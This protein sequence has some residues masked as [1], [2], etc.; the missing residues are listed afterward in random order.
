MNFAPTATDRVLHDTWVFVHGDEVHLFYLAMQVGNNQH[1]LIGHAVSADWLHWT[2]LPYIDLAGP[3]GSWDAGRVGTG[4]TF[5]GADGRFYMAYTGRIDPQEDIGLAVSDDLVNWTKVQDTPVWPQALTP[6][7]ETDFR[8][9]GVFQAW[10]DPFVVDLPDGNRYALLCAKRGDG[11]LAARACVAVARLDDLHSWTTREPLRTPPLFPTMEVPEIFELEGRWWLTFNAH[12]GWGRRLDTASRTMAGGT[13]CL[14]AEEPFG[15]WQLPEDSLLIGSGQ[16]RHDAVVA[17]SVLWQGER[18]VYHHYN[19]SGETGSARALGLP[20]VV[21][22]VGNRLVLRPWPGLAAIQRPAD[23]PTDWQAPA[24][25]PFSSGIWEVQNGQITGRCEHGAAVCVAPMDSSDV[26]LSCE[27]HLH[28]A[29]RAG[30]GVAGKADG[31]GAAVVLLDAKRHQVALTELR[32]GTFGPVLDPPVD[33]AHCLACHGGAH[34]LRVLK[35]HR[36][37]EAFLDDELVFST[38]WKDTGAGNHLVAVVEGGGA[39]VHPTALHAL[40]PMRRD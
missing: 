37:I 16:G 10:R 23:V 9:R 20:K 12:G 15:E 17:R 32:A 2:E 29:E 19:G 24:A 36:Y 18:L 11:P 28:E 21:E 39:M 35:R 27:I 31:L 30:I 1:R 5:Q 22:A 26:D 8:E 7:Y 6:P 14:V 40:E 38:V 34:R 4:H 13:F 33:V 25:G 3:A